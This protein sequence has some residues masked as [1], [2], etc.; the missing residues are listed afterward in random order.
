[1]RYLTLG[2]A[3]GAIVIGTVIYGYSGWTG[4]LV[5]LSFYL[6]SSL[7]TKL[8]YSTKAAKGASEQKAGA[9]NIWQT[10]GQGGVAAAFAAAALFFPVD[11]TLVAIGVVGALAEANADTWAVELGI[12]SRQ[13]PRLITQ[14]SRKVLPGKSGGVSCLGELSAVAGSVFV[15][16][17]AGVLGVLGNASLSPLIISGIAAVIGEH[18]DSV[19][20]AT[21][22]A[23]YYCP[24]CRK[25]TERKVHRCGTPTEHVKGFE[26]MTNEA[27]NF[28]STATAAVLALALYMLF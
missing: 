21:V 12:L 1:M 5:L 17:V 14:L 19:L 13:H 27:V 18:V 6:S 7:L 26:L 28:I 4:Y 23:A 20:G 10:I 9:R 2:G 22:Q 3:F 24:T 11:H 15:T 8:K 16:V 25:E